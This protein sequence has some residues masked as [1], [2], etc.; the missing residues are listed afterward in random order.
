MPRK[1]LTAQKVRRWGRRRQTGSRRWIH[2]IIGGLGKDE[3]IADKGQDILIGGTTTSDGDEDALNAALAAWLA[4]DSYGNR[5][6][7]IDALLTV[8]DD[9][10]ANLLVGNEDLD[11]F[12]ARLEDALLDAGLGETAL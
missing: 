12:F 3:L 11:L 1:F 2:L 9:G 4:P 6:D 5:V 8:E 10:E 7:V